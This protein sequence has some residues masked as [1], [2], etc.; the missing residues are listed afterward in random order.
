MGGQ[1]MSDETTFDMKSLSFLVVDDEAFARG[2]AVKILER[3][4]AGEITLASDGDEALAYL[5]I[6]EPR[7]DVL[8]VDIRMPG[9]N[10]IEMMR[11][12]KE[13]GYGG[14][15]ILLSGLDENSVAVAE[16]IGK[17]RELN[18]LGSINKPLTPEALAGLLA[19][20]G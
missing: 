20:L 6:A 17:H 10:G 16:W 18:V 12:L 8:L 1:L 9:M 11:V 2:F 13:W 5:E 19:G 7:P 4:G 15:I 14:A 3:M